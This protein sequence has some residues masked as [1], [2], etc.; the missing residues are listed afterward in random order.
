MHRKSDFQPPLEG[1]TCYST[2]EKWA[3]PYPEGGLTTSDILDDRIDQALHVAYQIPE[4]SLHARL[5][6]PPG[7]RNIY[8]LLPP[9]LS[10]LVQ[11]SLAI[12]D[13]KEEP[14]FHGVVINI[15]PEQV[16]KN[17]NW[18]EL[19]RITHVSLVS[20]VRHS[21]AFE[22]DLPVFGILLKGS[23]ATIEIG[24]WEETEDGVVCIC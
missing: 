14:C 21:H 20:M 4:G 22:I 1:S 23:E 13:D 10:D 6:L 7:W 19:H 5:A 2:I 17:A 3:K 24:W 18:D 15:V 11:K 12:D 8:Q 16:S 9:E